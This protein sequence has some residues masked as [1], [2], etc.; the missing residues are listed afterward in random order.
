VVRPE[1]EGGGVTW[2]VA[3]PPCV[4]VC[5]RTHTRARMGSHDGW[6]TRVE[7]RG[8]QSSIEVAMTEQPPATQRR[9]PR[10]LMDPDNLQRPQPGGMSLTSVQQWVLSALA[11]TT[12]AHLAAGL[13]VAAMVASDSRSDAQIGLNV[14]AGATAVGAVA[15]G[16]GIH[17]KNPVSWWLLLGVVV[18]PIG[19]YLTLAR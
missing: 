19:L 3:A 14:L 18:T 1:R 10:H 11:V 8:F 7:P 6:V 16:R 5:E 15:A 4:R 17:G 13:V 9:R 12:I 2:L